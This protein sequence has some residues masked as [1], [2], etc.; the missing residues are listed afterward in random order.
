V[1][2]EEKASALKKKLVIECL[3]EKEREWGDGR[4]GKWAKM[5]KRC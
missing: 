5:K 3:E 1:K 2:F 4:D